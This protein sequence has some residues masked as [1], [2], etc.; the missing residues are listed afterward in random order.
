MCHELSKLNDSACSSCNS[1]AL[2]ALLGL[3][4]LGLGMPTLFYC[5]LFY[6][7]VLVGEL[8]HAGAI[9]LRVA[10]A[11]L[12][13]PTRQQAFPHHSKSIAPPCLQG[14]SIKWAP[15]PKGNTAVKG[16]TMDKDETWEV[17]EKLRKGHTEELTDLCRVTMR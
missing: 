11:A 15:R 14:S 16:E 9:L 13:E 8:L 2:L 12:A 10:A 6:S 17:G 1:L 7:P 3:G 5:T 4:L